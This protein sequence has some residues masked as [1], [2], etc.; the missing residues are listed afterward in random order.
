MDC[1]HI[2]ERQPVSFLLSPRETVKDARDDQSFDDDL[3]WRVYYREQP[4]GTKF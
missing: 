4:R 1:I 3:D 2:P